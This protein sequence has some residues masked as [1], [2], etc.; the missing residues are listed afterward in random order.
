MKK[1][2][3]VACILEANPEICF[4]LGVEQGRN[5]GCSCSC[6]QAV[7]I[8]ISLVNTIVLTRTFSATNKLL[9]RTSSAKKSFCRGSSRQG[10]VITEHFLGKKMNF[11]F[12]E[13]VLGKNFF[14]PRKFSATQLSCLELP[15][16]G[17]FSSLVL[18]ILP[19]LPATKISYLGNARSYN[20]VAQNFLGK[21]NFLPST[22][23]SKKKFFFLPRKCSVITFPCRELPWQQLFSYR[24]S[25]CQ[26]NCFN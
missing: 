1:Q 9:P 21:K 7:P 20:V 18:D 25:S 2:F 16:Q 12:D 15:Q 3:L 17:N 13:K 4:A 19:G 22:F 10:N 26:H 14:L 8:E 24:E 23:S 6:L 11:S 5:Q